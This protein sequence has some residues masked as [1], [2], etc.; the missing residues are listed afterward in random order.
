MVF[1]CYQKSAI[2]AD[3]AKRL[4]RDPEYLVLR[5][6]FVCLKTKRLPFGPWLANHRFL[7][8]KYRACDWI[9]D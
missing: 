2:S 4:A 3:C 7:D 6:I 8:K 5:V 9:I 1:G